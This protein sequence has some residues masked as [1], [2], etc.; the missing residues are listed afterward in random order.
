MTMQKIHFL[1]YYDKA[2]LEIDVPAEIENKL[3]WAV[4]EFVSRKA[5]LYGANL[6][7]ANLSGANLYEADLCRAD[8]RGADLREANL[9]GANLG[10]ANLY[11]A[12]LRGTHLR[13]ADLCR[14]DLRAADLCRADLRGADLREANLYGANLGGANLIP[15]PVANGYPG[16]AWRKSEGSPLMISYGCHYG[17]SSFSLPDARAYWAGKENR[18]EI[19]AALDYAEAVAKTKGWI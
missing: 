2:P 11:E 15:L 4:Q 8:L 17:D 13:G 9:Y 19:Y 14:A 16:W 5:N 3:R 18:R 10:G 12:D 7:G 1:P 6:R